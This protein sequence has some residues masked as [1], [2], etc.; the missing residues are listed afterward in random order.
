MKS[1]SLVFNNLFLQRLP[2][3]KDINN[4][5]RTV[6]GAAYSFVQ[7]VKTSRPELIATNVD[8]VELLGMSDLAKSVDKLSQLLTGNTLLDGMQQEKNIV[9]VIMRSNI[10]NLGRFYL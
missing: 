8:L 7:P 3:D 10:L 6:E 2:A 1:T 4:C 5:C 9:S